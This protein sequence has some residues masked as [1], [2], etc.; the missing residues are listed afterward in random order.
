MV[1]DRSLVGCSVLGAGGSVLVGCCETAWL[2]W[3]LTGYCIA[4]GI[5]VAG[6]CYVGGVSR[7]YTRTISVQSR[8]SVWRV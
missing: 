7:P 1:V 3:V 8:F 6:Y 4:V 2:C 5:V